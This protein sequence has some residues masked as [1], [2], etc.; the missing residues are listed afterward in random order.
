[1]L[2]LGILEVPGVPEAVDMVDCHEVTSSAACTSATSLLAKPKINHPKVD[3]HT[4]L[5][6]MPLMLAIGLARRK[7]AKGG[8]Y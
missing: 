4:A 2:E 8:I 5:L 1:M 6:V 3:T 7:V